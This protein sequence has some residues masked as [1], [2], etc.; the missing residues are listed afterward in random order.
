MLYNDLYKDPWYF[1]ATASDGSWSTVV[2][3]ILPSLRSSDDA[4][5]EQQTEELKTQELKVEETQP[6]FEKPVEFHQENVKKFICSVTES[7]NKLIDK[8]TAYD[9]GLKESVKQQFRD[10]CVEYLLRG[11]YAFYETPSPERDNLVDDILKYAGKMSDGS[12]PQPS[13]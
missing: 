12:E 5:N 1:A 3:A 4:D 2:Y 8:S 6:V 10:N 9:A 7:F 13:E 11:V